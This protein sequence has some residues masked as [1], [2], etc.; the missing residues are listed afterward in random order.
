MMTG[1]EP[2]SRYAGGHLYEK[3]TQAASRKNR[4]MVRYWKSP[5][6]EQHRA[7]RKRALDPKE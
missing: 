1:G 7:F 2:R 5:T 6:Q 4:G 3:K